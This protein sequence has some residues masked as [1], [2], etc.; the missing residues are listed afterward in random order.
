MNDVTS[1]VLNAAHDSSLPSLARD[2]KAA[3]EQVK[4]PE[5]QTELSIP[6]TKATLNDNSNPKTA[7]L[8]TSWAPN[9]AQVLGHAKSISAYLKESSSTKLLA[10]KN[11]VVEQA[12]SLKSRLSELSQYLP[13]RKTNTKFQIAPEIDP[14]KESL[15][16]SKL[17]PKAPF[18]TNSNTRSESS[19]SL[20][21][22]DK[23]LPSPRDELSS[24]PFAQS[25]SSKEKVMEKTVSSAETPSSPIKREGRPQIETREYLNAYDATVQS[26]LQ[27]KPGTI[28]QALK[29]GI[30]SSTS[31]FL[32]RKPPVLPAGY[33]E[34]WLQQS[35][36]KNSPAAL[37]FLERLER[38]I[39]GANTQT[40][41]ILKLDSS[42]PVALSHMSEKNPKVYNQ[43]ML[44]FKSKFARNPE[45]LNRRIS[46]IETQSHQLSL[47]LEWDKEAQRLQ[48][49][50]KK[51]LWVVK[52][53]GNLFG[54]EF[55]PAFHP[56]NAAERLANINSLKNDQSQLYAF[57]KA[58]IGRAEVNR[59]KDF[60]SALAG[61]QA[62][63]LEIDAKK[64]SAWQ[65][66]GLDVPRM[67][68]ILVTIKPMEGLQGETKQV[69]EQFLSTKGP[70]ELE[71]LRG[72]FLNKNQYQIKWSSS[73]EDQELF[74]FS[75]TLGPL[76][77]QTAKSLFRSP[78]AKP[79]ANVITHNE[80]VTTEKLTQGK[81]FKRWL[82][83]LASIFQSIINK[84][85][86]RA[87][88]KSEGKT[89]IT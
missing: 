16:D 25:L 63:G 51:Y 47:L 34:E 71:E 28:Y 50:T 31:K 15:A 72:L 40:G 10:L 17:S 45:E 44:Y 80:A 55:F 89:K 59:R 41:V 57:W 76:Y 26:L 30:L 22:L 54:K 58:Y 79:Q 13:Y 4:L 9:T 11:K 32:D 7:L 77:K 66:Q 49:Q 83:K 38:K 33:D 12:G 73:M 19:S 21:S 29:S 65:M 70:Q 62:S 20:D 78:V 85:K 24:N 69:V 35:G 8:T 18:T 36:L 39:S 74:N 87:I 82:K 88:R 27:A 2:A 86:S 23:T 5:A 75:E 84:F 60:L 6:Q 43:A 42:D 53:A 68:N 46:V 56:N 1:A 14:P 37:K 48:A 67:L 81:W 3:T 52:N 61:F 64:L